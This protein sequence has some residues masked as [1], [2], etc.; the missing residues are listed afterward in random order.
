MFEKAF[1]YFGITFYFTGF[2]RSLSLSL[3]LRFFFFFFLLLSSFFFVTSSDY[4]NF[5]FCSFILATAFTLAY[6]TLV[7][8]FL[9]FS[10]ACCIV[11]IAYARIYIYWQDLENVW[12]NIT[13]LIVLILLF[14]FACIFISFSIF[15]F[16][17]IFFS[18]FSCS[19]PY[20]PLSLSRSCSI[21]K[22]ASYLALFYVKRVQKSL[23]KKSFFLLLAREKN[24]TR[25]SHK[26]PVVE[27]KQ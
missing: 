16:S 18:L 8:C 10:F 22:T 19:F 23:K 21:V 7:K 27:S 13:P 26:N 11:P 20:W 2:C 12:T 17:I 3:S 6:T 1:Y 4:P 5:R 15:I 25:K 14:F 9:S 24:G